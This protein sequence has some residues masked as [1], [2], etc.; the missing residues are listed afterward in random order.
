MALFNPVFSN[1]FPASIHAGE[2]VVTGPRDA[3]VGVKEVFVF[4]IQHNAVHGVI[5]D[6]IDVIVEVLVVIGRR[7]E[8]V[9]FFTLNLGVEVVKNYQQ[10]SMSSG[11]VAA[12]SAA[13]GA[14]SSTILVAYSASSGM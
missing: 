14:G 2:K 3:T 4:V 13:V 7:H 8:V 9:D 11:A 1:E 5:K 10:T 6:G 12:S